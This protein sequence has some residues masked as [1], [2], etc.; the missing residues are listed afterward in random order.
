VHTQVKIVSNENMPAIPLE[1]YFC[2]KKD[3]NAI[4]YP[5]VGSI[6]KKHYVM[7]TLTIPITQNS[8][9]VKDMKATLMLS[10]WWGF[11]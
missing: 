1:K 4:F 6:Q 2:S 8:M 5:T 11:S 3:G 7:F 9:Q 10:L